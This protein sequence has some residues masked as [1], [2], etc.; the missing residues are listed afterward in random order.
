MIIA[1]VCELLLFA[2]D[3]GLLPSPWEEQSISQRR[4]RI[5]QVSWKR[6]SVQRKAKDSI[7]WQS[8]DEGEPLYSFD[9]VLTLKNSSAKLKL[10]GNI[11]IDL[12]E[13]TLV[14]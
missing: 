6:Q 1:F 3:L 12:Q 13:N 4:T 10:E 7:L 2:A 9:S 8:S 5:G 14:V 11:Q